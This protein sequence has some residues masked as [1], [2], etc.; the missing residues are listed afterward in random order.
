MRGGRPRVVAVAAAA[1]AEDAAA[2]AA[3]RLLLPLRRPRLRERRHQQ[4]L[5]ARRCNNTSATTMTTTAAVR[6]NNSNVVARTFHCSTSCYRPR[7]TSFET[8]AAVPSSRIVR[9]QQRQDYISR[10]YDRRLLSTTSTTQATTSKAAEKKK[11]SGTT[12]S[13]VEIGNVRLPRVHDTRRSR[14]PDLLAD[15]YLA[16]LCGVGVEEEGSARLPNGDDVGG[17]GASFA[18]FS[19]PLSPS[20]LSHLQWM[21]KKDL[22]RQDMLLVGPP[23]FGAV[24][25]RRLAMAFAEL[26]ARPVHVVTVTKDTTESD[27]KQRR[28]L[29]ATGGSASSSTAPGGRASLRLSFENAAPVE[30]ALNGDILVLDGLERASRNVLPTLNNLLE[31]RSMNLEDGRFLVDPKRY[32]ELLLQKREF[33][34]MDTDTLLPVHPDFRVIAT[35]V[36]TTASTAGTIAA[37]IDPPL[38]SRFQIRRVGGGFGRNDDLVEQIYRAFPSEEDRLSVQP[39]LR[40]VTALD[41]LAS[42][43]G[44]NNRNRRSTSDSI[45]GCWPFPSHRVAKTVQTLRDF[46]LLGGGGPTADASS[47]E[48][49]QYAKIVFLKSYPLAHEQWSDT[50]GKHD[51]NKA[52]FD[53][54]WEE[55]VSPAS[56]S[57]ARHFE[58]TNAKNATSTIASPFHLF[59]IAPVAE[60]SVDSSSNRATV[61]FRVASTLGGSAESSSSWLSSVVLGARSCN[62]EDEQDLLSIT[63]PCGSNFSVSLPSQGQG[64]YHLTQGLRSVIVSML[65][66]HAVGNDMLLLAPPG[67]SKSATASYFASLL[68]YRTQLVHVH[69]EMTWSELFL[70]RVTSPET[71]ETNWEPSALLN[72]MRDG[73]VCILDNVQKLRPDVLAGLQS[74]A[75]DRDVYL[76]DGRRVLSA[77]RAAELDDDS[78]QRVVSIHPS[79]RIVALASTG[80][81]N[82]RSWFSQD[83]MSMF[84]TIIIPPP[85]E[86]CTRTILESVN[87]ECSSDDTVDLLLQLRSQLKG[88]AATDC[89]VRP[90]STRNLIR[91]VQR[92]GGTN[93][94]DL[95]NDKTTSLYDAVRE[96]L[97]A[98]LLPPTQRAA[99][100]SLLKRVGIAKTTYGVK[101]QNQARKSENRDDSD[102]IVIDDDI[103]T[104]GNFE[105]KRN[106]AQRIEMVPAP[107]FYDIPSHVY[108]IKD[109]LQDWS[110]GERAFLLLGNQGVGKNVRLVSLDC[111]L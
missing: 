98:D 27:L 13:F 42:G 67:E 109:L 2:I 15:G 76:P 95:N 71:G 80:E 74:L 88:D 20:Y 87:P 102:T 39:W 8:S 46:R 49:L 17:D 50:G 37:A 6:C 19:L 14:R 66:S 73:D 57:N 86:D 18:Q 96:V 70:R 91:I 36:P 55:T 104:I 41:M 100:E 3:S 35:A 34:N 30:A 89:G 44:G 21:M 16:K 68:G 43:G 59:S 81:E 4:L 90:L 25:R 84:D 33:E 9:Q 60:N 64:N 72:A 7:Q 93:S 52:V 53:S 101:D 107:K 82:R 78:R 22:L 11:D 97:V 75:I 38:R 62:N 31:H 92:V 103:C 65:Q 32:Q 111:F 12:A 56:T 106:R 61:T 58:T 47:S 77:Q 29:K 45:A 110:H 105:M 28:E 79:F 83:T 85:T 10:Y 94:N 54:T 5:G 40:F 48:Q 99:L 23:G 63:V 26:A 24:Q 51:N 1:A 108:A 69:S